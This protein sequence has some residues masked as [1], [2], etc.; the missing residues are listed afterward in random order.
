MQKKD[1]L[2]PH[3]HRGLP[4]FTPNNGVPAFNEEPSPVERS[5]TFNHT[6]TMDRG[7]A[8]VS[9]PL[10]A[11][12]SAASISAATPTPPLHQP[13]FFGTS[14][15][16][17]SCRFFGQSE[18]RTQPTPSGFYSSRL[19]LS[20]IQDQCLALPTDHRARFA[21]ERLRGRVMDL[22]SLTS[23][24]QLWTGLPSQIRLQ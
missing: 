16:P 9:Q 11:A 19:E 21:K 15:L 18:G 5:Q 4:D 3:Q 8:A 20:P 10:T 7:S 14:T 24:V 13:S 22:W 23:S 6:Y 1:T 17:A 12:P 2:S